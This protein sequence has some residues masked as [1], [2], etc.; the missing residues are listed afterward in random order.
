L[1]EQIVANELRRARGVGVNPTNQRR[2]HYHNRRLFATE[3]LPN[4]RL[5]SQIELIVS[6]YNEPFV[7]LRA[8]S[9]YNC[10]PYQ[11]TVTRYKNR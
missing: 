8:K 11:S 4:G 2:S 3:K 5:L 6:L 10:R 9:P 1:N 7:P